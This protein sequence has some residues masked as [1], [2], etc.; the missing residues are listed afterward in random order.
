MSAH[1]DVVDVVNVDALRRTADILGPQSAAA[2]ALAR[3]DE[4]GDAAICRP[5]SDPLTLVV[6]P[7]AHLERQP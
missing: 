3:A 6:I 4:I 2:Q 7:W 5:A 1:W